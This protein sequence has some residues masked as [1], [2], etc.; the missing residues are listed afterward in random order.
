MEV[1]VRIRQFWSFRNSAKGYNRT[2]SFS[3][4]KI[5]CS[6]A[7]NRKEH[8]FY[9]GLIDFLQITKIIIF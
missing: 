2:S 7:I 5:A 3:D 6:D 1:S 8:V 9:D 4:T